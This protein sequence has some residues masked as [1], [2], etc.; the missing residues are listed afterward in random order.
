MRDR[1]ELNPIVLLKVAFRLNPLGVVFLCLGI[2]FEILY[3]IGVYVGD[4]R[5]DSKWKL[6]GFF[7]ALF[8]ITTIVRFFRL[9]AIRDASQSEKRTSEEG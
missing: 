1:A 5:P 8:V 2:V 6:L 4:L 3:R 9:R 7:F